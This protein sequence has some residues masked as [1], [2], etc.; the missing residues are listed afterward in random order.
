[1]GQL[2]TGATH[3]RA[4]KRST[5]HGSRSS[6]DADDATPKDGAD[7]PD[8]GTAGRKLRLRTRRCQPE[9]TFLEM[10]LDSLFL[11]QVATSITQE[12]RRESDVPP[13]ERGTANLDRLADYLLP[14]V[15]G[16][17]AVAKPVATNGTTATTTAVNALE[18]AP[19][20]KKV[21]GAQARIV[22]EKVDDMSP[23][24]RAWFDRIHR[25]LHEKDRQEQGLH[26]GAPPGNGGPARSHRLQATDQGTGLPSGGGQEPWLP[27]HGHRRQRI[28]WTSSAA[29]AAA[30]SA[31]CRTSSAKPVT[32]N[33]TP[34]RRSVPCIRWRLRC[35]HLLCELTGGERAAVCNTGSEAVL[36]AMRMAR[37][38]TGRSLI[39]SFSGSYHGINDEVIIRGSKSKKSY[40]GA[41]GIMPEAV[42]HV[43]AGLRHPGKSGDHPRAL[44]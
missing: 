43:S 44:P 23:E 5:K 6:C 10:G 24:Q 25:A 14:H 16:A 33:W 18:D 34:V 35:R 20:L 11:T 30:C 32:S 38:V 28:T 15:G 21:F 31:T 37:T 22:K 7:P 41:P 27:P 13:T 29:S 8:Q 4:M 1:M 9:E 12:V 42:E 2:A 3:A 39:I 36:G 19:E 26:A 17:A 40:P